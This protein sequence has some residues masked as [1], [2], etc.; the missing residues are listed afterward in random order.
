MSLDVMILFAWLAILQHPQLC[1]SA[2]TIETAGTACTNFHFQGRATDQ[3]KILFY[4]RL[5]TTRGLS[6]CSWSLL[7]PFFLL[8]SILVCFPPLGFLNSA[9]LS[10]L[11]SLF[12]RM[13]ALCWVLVL[14]KLCKMSSVSLTIQVIRLLWWSKLKGNVLISSSQ[15][16]AWLV[17][18]QATTYFT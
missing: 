13:P 12:R 3:T 5:Q 15:A 4:G 18:F 11:M 17:D 1:L 7:G 16:L 9:F 8:S 14:D 2:G 6:F 10:F